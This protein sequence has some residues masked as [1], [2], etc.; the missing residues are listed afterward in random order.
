MALSQ[1]ESLKQVFEARIG[2][3]VLHHGDCI[4]A[5]CEA[6]CI[7]LKMGYTI[8]LHPPVNDAKRAFCEGACVQFQKKEYLKRNRDIVDICEMLIACPK[9]RDEKLRSG[10]W[11]TV[12]YAIAKNVPVILIF[13]DGSI[14]YVA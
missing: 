3:H 11:S 1:M 14:D 12:R 7:A 4:G 5:D 2:P 10:T 8:A 6:H 9:E 13:P